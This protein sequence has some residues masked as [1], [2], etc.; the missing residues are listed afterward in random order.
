MPKQAPNG[1]PRMGNI[2]VVT[3][4]LVLC[5]LAALIGGFGT[6]LMGAAGDTIA[7]RELGQIDMVHNGFNLVDGIG[8]EIPEGVAVDTSVSPN[9]VYVADVGN[10]RVLGWNNAAGF[11][12]GDPADLVIGQPDVFA[13]V[14]ANGNCLAATASTLCRPSGIAVDHSGNLYVADS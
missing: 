13:V 8:L 4:L 7:D 11:L 3:C 10:Y 6:T 1:R 9:R 5:A 12:N 2:T 14:P